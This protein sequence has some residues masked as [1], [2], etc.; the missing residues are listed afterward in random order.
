MSLTCG[1]LSEQSNEDANSRVKSDH[2]ESRSIAWQVSTCS[3]VYLPLF[4]TCFQLDWIFGM[5]RLTCGNLCEQS[6]EDANSRVKSDHEE[7]W[8]IAWQVSTW[9]CVYFPL[10]VTCFQRG[11][12]FGM[13]RSTCGNLSEQSNEDANSRVKS[14][15]EESWG[16][17]WQAPT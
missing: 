6:N 2:G 13:M 14:D 5:M 16:I 9:S 4:V 10:F 1:N 7:S 12:I 8:A 11:C 15:R 17:A 3:C